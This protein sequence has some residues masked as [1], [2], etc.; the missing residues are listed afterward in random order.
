MSSVSYKLILLCCL[1]LW[2][3][4]FV[5]KAKAKA[6][7]EFADREDALFLKFNFVSAALDDPAYTCTKVGDEV[8]T[9]TDTKVKCTA[10]Q[11]KDAELVKNFQA[12]FDK[13]MDN[14]FLKAIKVVSST[15]PTKIVEA[16]AEYVQ[17][18]KFPIPKDHVNTGVEK[19]TL[20]VYVRLLPT[21]SAAV[22]GFPCWREKHGSAKAQTKAQTVVGMLVFDQVLLNRQYSVKTTVRMLQKHALYMMAFSTKIIPAAQLVAPSS[23]SGKPKADSMK[24]MN[25]KGPETLKWITTFAGCATGKTVASIK[26]LVDDMDNVEFSG[27]H[28]GD[29]VMSNFLFGK[30]LFSGF[31]AKLIQDTGFYLPDPTKAAEITSLKNVGC[32]FF[33]DKCGAMDK[34]TFPTVYCTVNAADI[35]TD[36]CA[37]DR[38]GISHCCVTENAA[39]LPAEFQY[40]TDKKKGGCY[41]ETDYCPVKGV[42][43]VK[44]DFCQDPAVTDSA[45]GVFGSNSWCFDAEDMITLKDDT[46]VKTICAEVKCFQNGYQVKVK[47]NSKFWNCMSG[48]TLK[49]P[50]DGAFKA[51]SIMCPAK[52]EVCRLCDTADGTCTKSVPEGSNKLSALVAFIAVAVLPLLASR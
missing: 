25:F 30:M 23:P 49:L 6:P 20:Q 3:N 16:D 26:V 22:Q 7:V 11:V 24:E 48:K 17:C 36:G 35:K 38:M 41:V 32:E 42:S 5:L 31:T 14:D 51:G 44:G 52:E 4:Q 13:A 1:A 27:R 28:A 39:D 50:T 8:I 2:S 37:S 43:G 45:S 12:A 33:T 47:D 34:I 21:Y 9:L 10:E 40:F 46:K 19:G 29:D 15:G 18:K